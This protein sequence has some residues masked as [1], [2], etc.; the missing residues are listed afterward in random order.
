MTTMTIFNNTRNEEDFDRF[1]FENGI[2]YHDLDSMPFDRFEDGKGFIHATG[3]EWWDETHQQW[4]TEYE[5][6]EV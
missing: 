2:L 4:V 1:Y 6:E 3:R 5:D